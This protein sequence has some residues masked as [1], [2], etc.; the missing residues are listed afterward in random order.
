MATTGARSRSAWALAAKQD[1]VVTREQLHELGFTRAAIR[2]R[3]RRGRL[4]ELW[5]GVYL[6]GRR[7]ATRRGLFRAAVLACRHAESAL[8]HTSGGELMGLPLIDT[9]TI[10]VSVPA[11]VRRRLRGITCHP[12]SNLAE[13]EIGDIDGIR[14]TG[15]ATTLVD[16]A[17]GLSL[18]ELERA[19]ND[20]DKL[21]LVDPEALRR[22]LARIPKRPGKAKLRK[23]LERHAFLLTDSE[24][25]RR[26][27]PIARRA[28]L[29]LPLTGETVNGFKV[30]F[31]WPELKLVVETDGL[32]YHRTPAAQARD[33]RRDQAHASAGLV[34]LRFTHAQVLYEP[35]AVERTL[36]AVRSR[37][38]AS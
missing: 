27:I 18:A 26:F 19:V 25:E 36:R 35:R 10:H 29:P 9:S 34:P 13:W 20:A 32:R 30:D 24:L 3:L 4:C 12:R 5:P 7:N 11:N 17:P 14:V 38:L 6:V 1:D 31:Y 21:D 37:L 8:S 33:R 16:I 22:Q 23:L 2:H 28:G 15:T